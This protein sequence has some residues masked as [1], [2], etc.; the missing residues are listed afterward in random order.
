MSENGTINAE[1]GDSEYIPTP[2]EVLYVTR[3]LP[4]VVPTPRGD[5]I[6]LTIYQDQHADFI[7]GKV[8]PSGPLL[9]SYFARTLPTHSTSSPLRILELGAGTGVAGLCLAK[10]LE[11]TTT[12]HSQPTPHEVILTDLDLALPLLTHNITTNF[13]TPSP[14]RIHATRLDWGSTPDAKRLTENQPPFNLILAADVIY[15]RHLF[16]PLIETLVHLASPSTDVIIAYKKRQMEKETEFFERFGRWFEFE[17]VGDLD[18]G[19]GGEEGREG[20]ESEAREDVES[21]K[22][23]EKDNEGQ[24][25]PEKKDDDDEDSKIGTQFYIFK[26]RTRDVPLQGVSDAFMLMEIMAMD[27]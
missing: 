6:S 20:G 7:A 15:W 16:D 8:W 13:P 25:K 3:P 21:G 17:K 27:V 4:L 23:D 5:P 22:D 14:L 19:R 26:C 24:G 12:L 1:N 9:A 10:L 11:R 2:D 18:G